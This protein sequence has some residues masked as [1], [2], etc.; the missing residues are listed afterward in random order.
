MSVAKRITK[1]GGLILVA[2]VM[3]D[4]SVISY[5]FKEHK[6]D[7][8]AAK[9]GLSPDFHTIC[10]KD[11]LYDY[12]RLEDLERLNKAACLNRAE[13]FAPDGPADFMR[14]ELNEMSEE[15]FQAFLQFQ[16]SICQRPE[17]LGASSHIVD[18]LKVL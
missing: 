17:L 10:T 5:C 7:Q 12:V 8:V 4:Y 2:Y 11:D 6:W 16:M 1:K 3:N 13:I 18:V 15:E 14:R 9:G